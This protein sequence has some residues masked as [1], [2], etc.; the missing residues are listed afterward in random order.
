MADQKKMAIISIHGTLDM[1]YPPLILATTAATLDIETTIYFT[2][3]GINIVRKGYAEKLKV[4]PVGNPAM[5]MPMPIPDI[6]SALPGMTSMATSMM[7]GMAKKI[8]F[9]TIP[10]LLSLCQESELIKMIVCQPSLDMFGW[11]REYMIDGLEFAGAAA[12]MDYAASADIHL[13]F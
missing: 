4:S 12:F 11:K 13:A 8:G 6:V 9:P 7:K 5:P 3:Y 1:A 2:F 10:E